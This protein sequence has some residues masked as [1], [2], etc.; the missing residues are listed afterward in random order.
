MKK[1]RLLLA[2]AGLFV[3]STSVHAQ[4]A[5]AVL[6]YN[7]GTGIVA[8][9]TNTSSALGPPALGS[10]VNPMDPPFSKTQ[11]VAIGAGGEMT[12]Q[13][14]TPILNNPADAYGLDFIIFANSFFVANGG[15]GL[16]ETTSG[17]LSYHS[18]T[19]Q[20]QVSADD[21]NWYTLNPSLAPQPGEYFPT[22]GSGNPFLPV[23]PA[24][25]ADNFAGMTLGQIESLYNGSA[26]GTGYSLSWAQ[27]AEGNSVDLSSVDYVQIDVESGVLDLDAVT[28][29]PEPSTWALLLAGMGLLYYSRK[30]ARQHAHV[31]RRCHDCTDYRTTQRAVPTSI[32]S[33]FLLCLLAVSSARAVTLTENF[34][35]DPA[36][37]G[38]QIFGDT[39]LFL[40]DLTNKVEDVTWDSTQPNSYFYHPLGTTLT[41][42]DCFT[43]S[44]D[45]QLNDLT[46]LPS[47]GLANIGIG[48]LNYNE[49]TNSAF[50]RP[51]GITP[52][53]FEFDY[54]PDDGVE[55]PDEQPEVAGS[56]IDDVGDLTIYPDFF[57]IYDPVPMNYG[58]TYQ[59]TLTHAAGASSMSAIVMTN[60]QVY[61]TMPNVYPATLDNFALDTVAVDNYEQDSSYD[62]YDMFGH[63]TVGN[64]AVT[65]PP[66]VRNVS[67]TLSNGIPQ[68]QCG[69]YTG[70][71]YTLERSTDLMT[72][73]PIP[74]AT[75]ADGNII[76]LT[77]PTPP[78][79][80]AFYR[81]RA[82]V[83]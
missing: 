76:M 36:G 62:A 8:G 7:S 40:W 5:D 56:L 77:D 24:L 44:F 22:Y 59:V 14:S 19:I 82:R 45:I 13:M 34:T 78:A 43:V 51:D 2:M 16:N 39:N 21:V 6:S 25:A 57:F 1:V 10:G 65:L 17:T 50:S 80:N 42:D 15:S 12:L 63:G 35:N 31:V 68:V 73:T 37:D 69:T 47:E 60:G 28:V 74:P 48:L 41:I 4:S 20:I 46:C 55:D 66:V 9:Y 71:G 18:S 83:P 67:L 32:L 33:A 64:F 72:W 75:I 29:A 38:W 53:L 27:D 70:Y 81:I 49:A 58:T 26:G 61:S 79:A 52:N 3:M 23:N 11:L 54:Y 30:A